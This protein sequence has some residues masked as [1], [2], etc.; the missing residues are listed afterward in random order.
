[1]SPFDLCILAFLCCHLTS[2][3]LI[4]TPVPTQTLPTLSQVQAPL[5]FPLE[6][7]P[8]P[9]NSHSNRQ[10]NS[11]SNMMTVDRSA[12]RDTFIYASGNRATIIGGL[13]ASEGIT[14]SNLYS[15]IGIFCSFGDTFDLYNE[16]ERLVK[17]DLQQ[18]Q[19]GNYYIVT[20]GRFFL[21]FD[22]RPPLTQKRS[23]HYHRRSPANPRHA[24]D[25][26][27]PG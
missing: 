1:L 18:L 25:V 16:G 27:N 7:V 6:Y 24:S 12:W 17:R 10:T 22:N 9:P 8:L 2:Y 4:L 19:P 26:R 3:P 5:P 11:Q 14:N 23:H 20:D 15:M 21:R 13:W